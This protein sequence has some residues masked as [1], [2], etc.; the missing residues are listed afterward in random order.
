[1]KRQSKAGD[2]LDPDLVKAGREMKGTYRPWAQPGQGL[3]LADKPPEQMLADLE[4][5]NG[6]WHEL[7]GSI[8]NLYRSGMS[9]AD[10]EEQTGI[11]GTEQNIMYTASQVMMT[12]RGPELT[13]DERAHFDPLWGSGLLYELRALNANERRRVAK[14]LARNRTQDVNEARKTARALKDA[15]QRLDELKRY[16]FVGEGAGYNDV[17]VADALAY[18]SY[19]IA[20]QERPYSNEHMTNIMAALRVVESEA[21]RQMLEGLL[22]PPTQEELERERRK[23]RE[24]QVVR[25]EADELG[26]R[27]CM[28]V[29]VIGDIAMLAGTESL[30]AAPKVDMVDSL[31]TGYG[32]FRVPRDIGADFSYVP[33]PR[34]VSLDAARLPIALNVPYSMFPRATTHAQESNEKLLL[35]VDAVE[36]SASDVNESDD[37]ARWYL[38]YHSAGGRGA[39]GPWSIKAL[40]EFGEGETIAG[41]VIGAVRPAAD[42]MM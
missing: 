2:F 4:N 26:T 18:M 42:D 35:L 30:F 29:P 23:P 41:I 39:V 37:V 21:A 6:I 20:E 24:L 11:S 27:A 36:L 38:A 19:R 10:V 40:F 22:R 31:G 13:D 5:M 8:P 15:Q 7:A 12:L 17:S 9:P 28:P 33:L 1:M 14:F 32:A 3:V 16:G 25:L 34:W